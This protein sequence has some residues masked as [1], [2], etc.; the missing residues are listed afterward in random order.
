MKGFVFRAGIV[1]FFFLIEFNC[2]S[3]QQGQLSKGKV[4]CVSLVPSITEIV[5]ALGAEELLLGTTNQCDYPIQAKEKPKVGDFQ[6][7]DMER[8]IAIKPDVVFATLPIHQRVIEKLRELNVRV[9]VSAPVDIEG[10]FAEIESVGVILARAPVAKKLVADLKNRLDSL[11]DFTTKPKV[12]VEISLAPLMSV[13]SGVFINDIIRRAGGQNVFEKYKV[14]YPVVEPEAVMEANP[15]VILILHPL[16]S[17]DD[18]ERR[19]GWSTIKAV[20]SGRVFCHLDE[21]LFFR[22]GPRLVDG[23]ILLARLLHSEEF[24]R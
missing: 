14:S 19:V 2:G 24:N 18:V 11:P 22:P 13:G 7:P 1:L 5:Y 16:A 21:D 12:Y 23:V 17:K 6:S 15:D 4:R 20:Q 8:I 9:Y 3:R 10:V